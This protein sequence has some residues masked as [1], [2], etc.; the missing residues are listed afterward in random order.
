MVSAMS[1]ISL[2]LSGD[3][4]VLPSD[5]LGYP[6]PALGSSGALFEGLQALLLALGRGDSHLGAFRHTSSRH[7][8][9]SS[10]LNSRHSGRVRLWLKKPKSSCVVGFAGFLM[11]KGLRVSTGIQ[12]Q[13]ILEPVSRTM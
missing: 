6:L 3:D 9:N 4:L 7:L 2:R 1:A 11:V 12:E 8:S 10:R 13:V 5:S